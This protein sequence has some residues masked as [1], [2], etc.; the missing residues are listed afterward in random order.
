MTNNLEK[1][2]YKTTQLVETTTSYM[3]RTE[4]G[5]VIVRKK[6]NSFV[7]IQAAMEDYHAHR[8]L[9]GDKP[10]PSMLVMNEM[11]NASAE[12]REFF[13]KQIHEEYRCAEAYVVNNLAIR[14]LVSFYMRTVKKSYPIRIFSGESEA[15]KWL[16]KFSAK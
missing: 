6:K 14:L 2:F 16:L 3:S 5:V 7:D 13:S 9:A 15:Y 12:T 10:S 8:K 4:H 1:E 11:L